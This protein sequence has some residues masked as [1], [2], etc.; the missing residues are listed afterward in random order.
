MSVLQGFASKYF[1]THDYNFYNFEVA[2]V[3]VMDKLANYI[4]KI[5]YIEGAANITD[6][7]DSNHLEKIFSFEDFKANMPVVLDDIA[8]VLPATHYQTAHL[9]ISIFLFLVLSSFSGDNTRLLQLV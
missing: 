4:Q 7:A 2:F 6:S 9:I 3:M 1:I 8:E 5:D